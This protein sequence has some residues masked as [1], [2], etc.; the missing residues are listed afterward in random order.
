MRRR[1]KKTVTIINDLKRLILFVH[2]LDWR[3]GARS[4]PE[5]YPR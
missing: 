3:R 5:L 2:A 1:A 4:Q